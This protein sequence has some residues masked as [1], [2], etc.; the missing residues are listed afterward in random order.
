MARRDL[1]RRPAAGIEP[2][3]TEPGALEVPPGRLTHLL[4]CVSKHAWEETEALAG[5]APHGQTAGDD[6][7]AAIITKLYPPGSLNSSVSCKIVCGN[8][9]ASGGSW[10]RDEARRILH[11]K[12]N[13]GSLSQGC[14]LAWMCGQSKHRPVATPRKYRTSIRPMVSRSF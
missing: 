12:Q 2:V 9:M 11:R 7:N 5:A 3:T 4:V 14:S 8:K 1:Q 13:H 10:S 6:D